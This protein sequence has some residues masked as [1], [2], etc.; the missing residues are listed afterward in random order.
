[1]LEG[2]V[3]AIKLFFLV[4]ESLRNSCTEL[5]KRLQHWLEI[6]LVFDSDLGTKLGPGV[7]EGLVG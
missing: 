4:I 6:S 3:V 7:L 2:A 1:M 5:H